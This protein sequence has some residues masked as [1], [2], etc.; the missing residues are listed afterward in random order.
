MSVEWS[1]SVNT[2]AMRNGS[3]WQDV[4]GFV[5]DTTR[6]GKTKRRLANSCAKRQFGV[7]MLFTYDEYV[8]FKAWYKN[9][10]RNG[11]YSFTFPSIDTKTGT[12]V[13]R[14]VADNV[15]EYSNPSGDKIECSMQW[16]EVS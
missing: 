6:S 13:Y 16:E 1:S 2:N 9:V 10:C 14:F 11:F 4:C 7:K 8:A 12:S 3:S 5:E 15:P